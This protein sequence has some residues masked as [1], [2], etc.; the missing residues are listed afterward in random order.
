MMARF[1]SGFGLALLVAI[2]GCAFGGHA[3]PASPP[4]IAGEPETQSAP[5]RSDAPP[6]LIAPPPAYGN[7]VVL[8]ESR[9]DKGKRF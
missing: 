7:K 6:R 5:Q 8:A 9:S 3:A 4:A 2:P 1:F